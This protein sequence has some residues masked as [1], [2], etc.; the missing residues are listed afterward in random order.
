MNWNVLIT[1]GAYWSHGRAANDRLLSAGC[2]PIRSAAAGPLG[3]Q[4]FIPQLAACDAVVA[5]SDIYTEQLFRECPNLKV[6]SRWGVGIDSID[7]KAATEAGVVVTN[8]PGAMVDAV[9][10]YT[11]G[12][13]LSIA[14]R[15]PEGDAL[16]R[17]GGWA[18][19]PGTLVYGKTLGLVGAGM[20][21]REVA[22]RAVG[23][24]MRILAFDP[25]GNPSGAPGIEFVSLDQLVAESDFVSIHAPSLPETHGM[26]NAARFAQMKRT[27]FLINAARGALVNETDLLDALHAG[28]IAGAAIDV[29]ANEP[30]PPGH[31]LRSAPRCVLMP[32]NASMAVE[33]ME[34]M[35]MLAA[36]NVLT[37][38]LGDR[39]KS[40]C[41]PDVWG[42]RNLRYAAKPGL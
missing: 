41:N 32:H 20:I 16:M 29:Y 19:L 10:D 39:P 36:E 6:V 18:E 7:L 25:N 31:P 14:R 33:T 35:S 9:A 3:E 37:Y 40:T 4:E 17:S 28:T 8:T 38:L 11:F 24:N 34:R 30:L 22:K 12:L 2:K 23:F 5:A 26:F 27:A 15:I 42:S 21:G 1:A 13:L